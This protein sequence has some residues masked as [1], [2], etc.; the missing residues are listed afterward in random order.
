MSRIELALYKL[1]DTLGMPLKVE[2]GK[3]SG[4]STLQWEMPSGE[5]LEFPLQVD[6]GFFAEQ[7]G[8]II[9]VLGDLYLMASYYPKTLSMSVFLIDRSRIIVDGVVAPPSMVVSK[10]MDLR[11]V[12]AMIGSAV[13]KGY[14]WKNGK[15]SQ[16]ALR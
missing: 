15:W 2:E 8:A 13:V 16:L 11:S 4:E 10:T 5:A 1:A 12:M 7:V 3:L 9:H 6:K 14:Y